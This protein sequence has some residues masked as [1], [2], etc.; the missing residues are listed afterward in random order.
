MTVSLDRCRN[1]AKILTKFFST[2]VFNYSKDKEEKHYIN[3]L[4]DMSFNHRVDGFVREF[5]ENNMA[6]W[7][8]LT[9][10]GW[11]GALR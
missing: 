3:K 11:V 8:T 2:R 7:K 1:L 9:K 6:I 5:Q 10:S 4:A